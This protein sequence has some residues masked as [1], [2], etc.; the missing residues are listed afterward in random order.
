MNAKNYDSIR[1]IFV[2]ADESGKASHR[3]QLKR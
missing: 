1:G 2:G 3:Q